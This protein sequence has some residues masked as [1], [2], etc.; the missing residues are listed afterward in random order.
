L[1]Y[2]DVSA[3]V[4]Y[5]KHSSRS[6]DAVVRVYDEAGDVI[7]THEHTGD[8]KEAFSRYLPDTPFPDC[9]SAT[10]LGKTPISK[11][12]QP[13]LVLHP[14]KG[15]LQRECCTVAPCTEGEQGK[16]DISGQKADQNT[17]KEKL[18]L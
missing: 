11:V 14:E 13:E 9:N 2:E 5:A 3:A 12:Q 1:W 10:T 4:D 8:F 17:G 16:G 15:P 6:H 7:E 18:R